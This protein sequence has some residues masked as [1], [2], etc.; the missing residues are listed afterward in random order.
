M[1]SQLQASRLRI[2]L[3]LA[4][5]SLALSVAGC[6]A[7]WDLWPLSRLCNA[8]GIPQRPVVLGVVISMVPIY[9]I[10]LEIWLAPHSA[11]TPDVQKKTEDSPDASYWN[12][13]RIVAV[14]CI[15]LTEA[16]CQLIPTVGVHHQAKAGEIR[17]IDP[18]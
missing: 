9:F 17:R 13:V 1:S 3:F 12:A 2:F 11:V 18:R 5:L 6:F 15:F 14:L 8:V 10:A 4:L 16:L 7:L